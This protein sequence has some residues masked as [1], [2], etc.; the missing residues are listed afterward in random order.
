[1]SECKASP[2]PFLSRISLEEEKNTPP[3]DCT[4]YRQLIGSLFYLTHSRTDICYVMNAIS[5]YMKQPH[6]LHW[7]EAKR[8]LQYIQGTRTYGIH[9]ATDSELELVG[10]TT[11]NWA[12]DSIDQ[13]STFGY[14][15]MFGG[16]SIFWSSKK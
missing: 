10:Y 12:G 5:R 4:I 16:G 8:I 1:M 9:Y 2:F 15:F 7:K 13:K 3:M 6:D 11:S 14:V